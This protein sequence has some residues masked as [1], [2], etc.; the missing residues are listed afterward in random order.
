MAFQVTIQSRLD[1][2]KHGRVWIYEAN[3]GD[4][5][6]RADQLNHFLL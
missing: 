1:P 3:R 4:F 2:L 6:I 5:R